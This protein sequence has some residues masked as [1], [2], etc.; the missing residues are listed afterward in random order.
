MNPKYKRTLYAC[1]IGYI[2]QAVVNNIALL[3]FVTFQNEFQLSLEQIGF[4]VTYNFSVQMAIDFISAKYVDAWGYKASAVAAHIFAAIGLVALGTFPYLF[5]SPYI[6]LLAAFTLSGLGGGL[7]EV[8]ISPI[9]EALPTDNKS[10]EMSLL[11]SF[12]CWG[13]VGVVLLATLYFKI[14]G[15]E[16]W[17]YL[18]FLMALIPVFNTFYFIKAPVWVLVKAEH[19]LSVRKL[20]SMK[21]FWLFFLLMI[22]SGAAEQ[23]MNQWSSYFAESGLQVSKT[24]G[25]LLG[26]CM[27]AVLM[28]ISRTF[29]GKYGDKIDLKLFITG[30]SALCVTSYLLAVFSPNPL[31]S[32]A[33]CGLCGLSVGIMWPGVF[34]LA[35]SHCPQG[36]T[37]MFAFLAL[38]GDIG[39]GSGPAVVGSIAD[40][41][42]GTIKAGLAAAILFPALL[43]I[44]VNFLRRKE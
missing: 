8:L 27:F 25:D 16:N 36:G 21:L 33:G 11:H 42:G 29:Y 14:A 31:L 24:A 3:L 43:M 9:V 10:S 44:C 22:C 20:A 39:C 2:T 38:A 4:L 18:L 28:G 40:Q 19:S 15:I 32:L 34:S 26:P 7:I 12:Y 41:F 35:A 23:A 37:A 5:P 1:Y 6:G 17:R 13:Y 30:S